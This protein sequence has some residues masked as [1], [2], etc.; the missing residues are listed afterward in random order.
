MPPR[1]FRGSKVNV[2]LRAAHVLK[3]SQKSSPCTQNST[4]EY[5]RLN[6]FEDIEHIEHI[7]HNSLKANFYTYSLYK[8]LNERFTQ[9]KLIHTDRGYPLNMLNM[10]KSLLGGV[11]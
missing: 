8:L 4:F 5:I 7:G 3:Y 9:V 10:L 1:P 6:T 11:S 2:L